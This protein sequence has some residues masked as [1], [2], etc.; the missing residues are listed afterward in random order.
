[1]VIL[2]GWDQSM[3]PAE[4]LYMVN[5]LLG[6]VTYVRHFLQ[7]RSYNASDS[8]EYF[9]LEALQTDPSTPP[10]GT[11]KWST[12]ATLY[13]KSWAFGGSGGT[14]LWK[15]NQRVAKGYHIRAT[16]GLASVPEKV[17]ASY[18]CPSQGLEQVGADAG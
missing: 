4:R 8:A 17:G 10:A 6:Q 18:P 9:Y 3:A 7:Q 12:V 14:P 16:P 11:N 2:S 5:W 13:F 15:D 1:M